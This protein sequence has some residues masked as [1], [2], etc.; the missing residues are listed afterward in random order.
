MKTFIILIPV[1]DSVDEPRKACEMVE[2]TTFDFKN[3]KCD[4]VNAT[5]ILQKIMFELGIEIDHNI[6]VEPITDFMDRCNNEEFN[7]DNYFISY[8]N[9]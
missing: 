3:E 8:V 5:K 1:T 7:P 4:T 9:A 6:E 2:N